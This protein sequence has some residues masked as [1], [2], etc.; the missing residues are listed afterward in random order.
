MAATP[1]EKQRAAKLPASPG[2]PKGVP[3]KATAELREMILGALDDAHPEGGRAYLAD[4]AV[5]N[6]GPFLALVGKVLPHT[7]TNAAPTGFVVSW[8]SE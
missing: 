7:I 1:S 5:K 8:Q 4:Q 3:N 6:P 2:R